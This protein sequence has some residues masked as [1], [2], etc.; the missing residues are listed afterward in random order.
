MHAPFKKFHWC[1]GEEKK[2]TVNAI[3]GF[4]I[5]KRTSKKKDGKIFTGTLES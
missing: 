2:K 4:P 1:L 3:L 5:A